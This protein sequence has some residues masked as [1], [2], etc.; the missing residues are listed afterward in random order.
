MN[1][2]GNDAPFLSK[3]VSI[4]YRRGLINNYNHSGNYQSLVYKSAIKFLCSR[5][6]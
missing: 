3:V 1:F 6:C 5:I 2:L 4:N